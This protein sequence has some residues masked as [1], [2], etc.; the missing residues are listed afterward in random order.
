MLNNLPKKYF[1]HFR[2]F[3]SHLGVKS[4][5][6][7]VLSMLVGLL[8]GFGLAMF[9]PMLEMV[10]GKGE[11]SSGG[12]G[13][14]DFILEGM[15]AVGLDLTLQ[16]VLGVML[17]FFILKGLARFLENCYMIL[18]QEFFMKRLR[19]SNVDKLSNYSFKAFVSSDAGRIQNTLSGETTKVVTSFRTYFSTLQAI[20][21]LCVYV[22][23]AYSAN[24]QFAILVTIGG[25]L[26]NF[27]FRFVYRKTMETSRKITAD[28]HLFQGLLIQM[29]N[30]FKYLKATGLIMPFA[31]KLKTMITEI[32]NSNKKIGYYNA[33]LQSIREPIVMLIVVVVILVQV[34]FFGQTLGLIIL[35]LLFF[36][37]AL[38]FVLSLQTEWNKFLN[39][40][41]SL[42]NMT[43]FQ[44]ELDSNQ[45][46]SGDKKLISFQ[47][48]LELNAIT[49]QYGN[50]KVLEDINLEIKKNETVAFVGESGAGKST[51]LNIIT[52]LMP[53]EVGELKIDGIDISE[54]TLGS[55]QKKIG[56]ITQEPVIFNASVYD[57]V[58]CWAE[59]N[60]ENINRFEYSL[61]QA[62]IFEFVQSLESK[63]HEILG[64]N[65][66]N[67]SGGQ[68]QRIS[69][70]RELYKDIDILIMDEATSAL[71]SET[72]VV[73]K[74]S[75]E[76]I[77]GKY[78]ILIVAHRISTIRTADRI[79]VMKK[80]KIEYV[81]D[82]EELLQ[83]SDLF[84][85]MVA[86]QEL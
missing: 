36:Y 22:F 62:S 20:I 12:M 32:E 28:S 44:A 69:I 5:I 3:Y 23:L 7:L 59:V 24:P 29:V 39:V 70:A 40:S 77:K 64:N 26:S 79:V 66:I 67:V 48:K 6:T 8:D 78:T 53:V 2:Y 50:T 84:K 83:K 15:N 85:K 74:Q 35:S 16:S 27:A 71:D 25:I 58:T 41:G 73:I 38:T 55:F 72:E 81:D 76:S 61:K 47:K 60:D 21:M 43:V 49:F 33:V 52:G 63:E 65:G 56:Y 17:V 4:I 30:Y 86:L 37:R 42:E 31:V 46:H 80:G 75:I 19:F 1:K 14:L 11:A 51:M 10:N 54:F 57:N 13:N 68:K 34:S 18:L 82:Y 45:D 9:L